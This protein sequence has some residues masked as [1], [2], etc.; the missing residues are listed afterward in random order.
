MSSSHKSLEVRASYHHGN[1]AAALIDTGF[2]LADEGGTALVTVR[3]AARR[4]G[5][6]APAAYRH[7]SSRN[8]LLAAVAQRCREELARAM[9]EARDGHVGA[10][11]RFEAVGR[12]YI[13]FAV[14]RPRVI[15]C[16]FASLSLESDPA[17]WGSED[18]S[19]YVVL[20]GALDELAAEGLLRPELRAGAEIVAWS[21]VHGIALLLA[22]SPE[23]QASAESMIEVVL[24]GV[25]RSL[26]LNL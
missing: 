18:P 14:R 6:S 19:A 23:L 22:G 26:G 20:S 4:I 2:A 5:V 9:I 1:L 10:D 8:D 25:G 16:A 13:E 11:A 3:E 24:N 12:S 21:S 17:P 15:E 7:F